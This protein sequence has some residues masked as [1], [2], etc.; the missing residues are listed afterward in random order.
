MNPIESP[1]PASWREK[2]KALLTHPDW[3]V[4]T[5]AGLAGVLVIAGIVVFVIRPS[6]KDVPKPQ[7]AAVYSLVADSVSKSAPIVIHLPAEA[8]VAREK[9]AEQITFTPKIRGDWQVDRPDG[10]LAF[11]PSKPLE[12]GKYYTVTLAT[13]KGAVG[14]DFLVQ[15]DPEV[16]AVFPAADSE[17]DENSSITVVFN[18]PMVPIST[19]GV[20]ET[21]GMPLSVSPATPG[22][23]KWIGTR[24]VQ[25]TADDRL[26]RASNY[27]IRVGGE[28]KSQDGLTV[29]SSETK[30]I[31]RPL[32]YVGGFSDSLVYNKPFRISFNQ[33]V[34][35]ERTRRE[36]SA[37]NITAN[38]AVE[39][40]VE[41]GTEKIYNPEKKTYETREN[42]SVL[43]IYQRRDAHGRVKFWDFTN[44]YKFFIAKAYPAE[45]DMDLNE[46]R[47]MTATVTDII[48]NKVAV[49]ARSNQT[50]LDLFDPEGALEI[51]F[52]EP[53]DIKKSDIRAPELAGIEYGEKCEEG[54]DEFECPKIQNRK[55]LVLRFRADRLQKGREISVDVR[56][57][58]NEEG[59]TISVAPIAINLKMAPALAV[60][61]TFPWEN[62]AD[63]SV[64]EFVLCTNSPL[65]IPDKKE[66]S[67]YIKADKDYEF[68][69][70]RQS[71][72][73]S[74]GVV[75]PNHCQHGEFETGINFGLIPKTPYQMEFA[76]RDHF[77]SGLTH[78]VNF[79]TGD[80]PEKFLNFYHFHKP[81]SVTVPGR[82]ALAY[83]VENMTY[84]DLH[85]CKTSAENMLRVLNNKPKYDQGAETVG[86]CLETQ[87]RRLSLPERFWIKNYFTVDIKDFFPDAVGHY[88]LTFSHP[89]YRGQSR[90]RN[91]SQVFERTYL[92]VTRFSLVEKK[93]EVWDQAAAAEN[94]LGDRKD[95]LNNLYWVTD[96]T[97]LEP[98]ANAAVERYTV[99]NDNGRAIIK[100]AG[101]GETNEQGIYT[102]RP[103]SEEDAVVVSKGEDSA[104]TYNETKFGWSENAETLSKYYIYTDRPIYR[105]GHQVFIKGLYR[106]GYDGAYEIKRDKPVRLQI[107]DSAQ[108]EIYSAEVPIN[109]FG[110]FQASTT[111]D[112]AA[113]LGTYRIEADGL[114]YGSFTT[115]EYLPAPFKVD[116]KAVKDE[117]I[118]G[119]SA[120]IAVDAAYY[121]GVPVENA[122]VEYSIVSQDY[123]F[124]KYRGDEYFQF[125]GGWYDCYDDCFYN[126]RSLGRGTM[127]LNARGNG[128]IRQPL[129]F[130]KWF[131]EADRNSKIIT[132]YINVKN[133][134]GQTVS[135]RAS[136]IAHAGEYYLGLATPG[137][138]ASKSKAQEIKLKSVSTEGKDISVRGVALAY[139]RVKWITNKR[140]GLDGSYYH[141]WEKKLEQVRTVNV[142][143]DGNGN[144]RDSFTPD[145]E[146]EYEIT[147]RGTDRRGNTV[148]TTV[149]M[150][151]YGE[152]IVEDIEPRNDN[153]LDIVVEDADVASGDTASILIKSP[154][155]RAKALISVERG[156]VYQ[157]E[158]V[159]VNQ[160][161]YPYRFPI[162]ADYAPN[163][164]AS[165]VLVSDAPEV[166]YGQV[167]FRVD[168]KEHELNVSVESDK[169]EYL[170]GED[171]KLVFTAKDSSGKPVETEFS[172][173]VV[174]VSV[175]ALV[176]NPKKN[177]AMFFYSGFPLTVS[178]YSNVKNFLQKVDV[179]APGTKG[180]GGGSPDDLAR[181]KRGDFRDTAHW[182]AV[183]RTN[184]NGRAEVRFKLPD[185]LTSWQI[186]AVGLSKETMLGVG[187]GEFMVNKKLMAVPLRPRFIIPGDHFTLGA[188]IFNRTDETQ[189]LAAKLESGTLAG[190][191]KEQKVS[192][193]KGESRTVY[194]PVRAP[195][196]RDTGSHRFTISVKNA[197]Y[198]D[199]VEQ[200]IP[201]RRNNTYETVATAGY[202]AETARLE[203][204]YVPGGVVADKGDVTVKTNATLAVF[205]SDTLKN[206]LEYPG[207]SCEQVGSK[208]ETIAILKRASRLKNLEGAFA[209]T[210][211]D[212][213][214]RKYPVEEAVRLGLADIYE[215]QND[216]G[217]FSYYEK[218]YPYEK[219]NLYLSLR[220][221]WTLSRLRAA[222]FTV[223]QKRLDDLYNYIVQAESRGNY[224]PYGDD[225]ETIIA[226][227]LNQL[228]KFGRTGG[229]MSPGIVN[230]INSLLRSTQ[231]LNEGMS[232]NTLAELYLLTAE[233]PDLFGARAGNGVLNILK[234]RI[235]I[236]ARGAYLPSN[237]H[238]MWQ[239]YETN[240]KNTALFLQVSARAKE[241][242]KVTDR[243][244][245]WLIA[246]R[247]KD[248][249]W[250]S[251]QNTLAVVDAFTDFLSATKENE[252]DFTV[253]TKLNGE[254]KDIHR[255]ATST[256]LAEHKQIFPLPGIPRE[257]FVPLVLEKENH[258]KLPN[259]LYYDVAM[260]Y[261]LPV[262]SLPPRDEGFAIE[263]KIYRLDDTK[264]ERPV[265]S[266]RAGEVLRVRNEIVVPR[267]RNFVAIEDF[268]PAG[269][270]IVNTSLATEDQSLYLN[271]G[272]K[273]FTRSDGEL[274]QIRPLYP[275]VQEARDD[276][277]YASV[278]HLEPGTY[279]IEYYIRLLVPGNY[280]HLPAVVSENYFPE[281]F[282]RTGGGT[283]TI[284]K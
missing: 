270:E 147:A 257:R 281:N 23:Y 174:D 171:V 95:G 82:T 237:Q 139:N 170:P 48:A 87:T 148:M 118:A 93:I 122:T 18:R 207:S 253:T 40:D 114:G 50:R 124:D 126:D 160:S 6:S 57:I 150:Y 231:K 234:N 108:K 261:Y 196:D 41:Y 136:F 247:A 85:V 37:Q 14:K 51:S 203:T 68:K 161:L 10:N 111:L 211:V 134:S 3:R 42:R 198:E 204:L 99:V 188:T 102:A 159:D 195:E 19:L 4:K 214:G 224:G 106:V 246:S 132:F 100:K 109:E 205:L 103:I 222:G 225:T 165:V 271:Q 210:D 65:A 115:E 208:L 162:K 191:V 200:T 2:V 180:G 112:I 209:V 151:V 181:R 272:E 130:K 178:T 190:D 245:R 249:S 186:E 244:L 223:E 96:L 67:S 61:R 168:R 72:Y 8:G 128:L 221:A 218:S 164:Y 101:G 25:F 155:K 44:Q 143:T 113:P 235:E 169:K 193:P 35:L 129:D 149:L 91:S 73:I 187:Y 74:G 56:R 157:Y 24:T 233:R 32:R 49:S 227:A 36:I 264:N 88:I 97:T 197:S 26:R 131:K 47:E 17:A 7:Y 192:V 229:D 66:I 217:G 202:G 199:T 94:K 77:G 43:N 137:M 133:S 239:Y 29:P 28:I 62:Q 185:N 116:A 34:D 236:D 283:F 167:S 263:R 152:Q 255:F 98:V 1:R 176:G 107:F 127:T 70:W 179:P 38:R 216:D 273:E 78:K 274:A 267:S 166:R 201:I 90:N 280:Q 27:T 11:Q 45:G 33:P 144:A 278:E 259:T 135:S 268:I 30:F 212:W 265:S 83:A 21:E 140:Q 145:K 262:K 12:S 282:G 53:V 154:Y 69:I 241:D 89:D 54:A 16:A 172:A 213:N 52:F 81:Y 276:R 184:A 242:S 243:L 220:M 182:D 163:V 173:A 9:A 252:S 138:F 79:T 215:Y 86:G 142:T 104:F 183:V 110:T 141:S 31:T 228:G 156:N 230:R 240:V 59:K 5:F 279:S 238:L 120:E 269:A 284:V 75:Q 71:Q 22:K 76:L 266:G 189:N 55:K 60:V 219:S 248:G 80:M 20:L 177:P 84:V 258:N 153:A 250:G 206:M 226:S 158:I 194:F 275:S 64:S 175:L 232:N 125:G 121:F 251:T 119:D 277:Y 46:K 260:R 256:V 15:D 254:E 63:G 92:T 58:V 13:D 117:Y 146:G 39:L 123:Y 105:P